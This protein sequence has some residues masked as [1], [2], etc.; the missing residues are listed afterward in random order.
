MANKS[1]IEIILSA[2][3]TAL[4]A[5]LKRS[6]TDLK[7]FGDSAVK[8]AARAKSAFSGLSTM[9]LAIGGLVGGGAAYYANQVSTI[10]DEYTNL[11]SRLKLVTEDEKDLAMVR[12]QLYQI[13]Q[14]T[15]TAYAGNADSY[16]KLA[17]SVKD[18]G[19][20]S[21]ETLKI[22]ELVNKSLVVNGST[23]EMASSFMLQFAQALGSGV[24]QGDEFRAMLE[25][26]GFFASQLAKALDTNIS[27]LRQMS[28]DGALTT[29]LLRTAFPKMAAAINAEFDKIAPTTQRAMMVLEN[30]FKKIIDESNQAAGGT[31]KFS[32]SILNLA[33]TIDQNRDGIISLFTF[34]IDMAAGATDK[35]SKLAQGFVNIGQS[36]KGW[37]AVFS[38]DL[39]FLEFAAMDAKELN[40]W[41]KKNTKAATDLAGAAKKADGDIANSAKQTGGAQKAI[42]KEALAEMKK[43][44][45]SYADDI[46][47]I[48][49]SIGDQQRS[50]A[51]KL[52]DMARS[53][54]TDV[55]AWKDR[56]KEAQEFT[57]KAKAA[58]AAAAQLVQQ[59]KV[60]AGQENYKLALEYAE[61]AERAYEGLNAEVKQGDAVLISQKTALQTA[62]AGVKEA[63]DL[64]VKLLT[65]QTAALA[66]AKETLNQKSGGELDESINK[67]KVG[68]DGLVQKVNESKTAIQTA[69]S[70]SFQPPDGDWNKVWGAM[71]SGSSGAAKAVSSDWDRVWDEFLASGSEDIATLESKLRELTRDREVKVVIREVQARATGGL[72]HRLASGGK[73][74]GYGGGDRISALLEAGEYVIRK[75]AVAK[76][77]SGLFHALNNLRIPEIP[78]FATGGPVGGGDSMTV[79]L[80]FSG[81]S[82]VPVTSTREQARALI[83]EFDRMGWRA[84]K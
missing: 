23:T 54:M 72:I 77:G 28:K 57:A 12:E 53:G 59:G 51:E 44:Y 31:G 3:D 1:K 70:E 22:T 15:G 46:K 83:R 40:E 9:K 38:G 14:Q 24:L 34:I 7:G 10:A 16:A 50:T 13:S 69:L 39:S 4:S 56:Q 78:R 8:E 18:L 58:A 79:N 61:K 73:L 75:E 21:G 42:T 6:K 62:M 32:Q 25:S 45:K 67:A 66:L 36:G 64:K 5:A 30:A 11:N 60:D 20:T 74:P 19:G 82:S 26:N 63:G 81:G 49:A 68:V 35:V 55:Q 2:Q 43:Q 27:G 48:Q 84:S 17:R 41:L 80:A 47:K 65:D 37:Q 71:E 33:Q 29:D 52:R 76:F